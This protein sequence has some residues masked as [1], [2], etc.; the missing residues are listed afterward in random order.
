LVLP[1]GR[2]VWFEFKAHGKQPDEDQDQMLSDLRTLGDE[3]SW[4][5]TIEDM[6]RFWTAC[7][8]RLAANAE[9]RAM[10]LDGFVDSRIAKAEGR[11][12]PTAKRARSP[13]GAPR[14]QAGTAFVRRAN[15]AGILI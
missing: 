11:K 15:K 3:A 5:V 8:A 14:N 7:G 2:H 4:G 6:R 13:K 10:V 1:G 9:Y 12:A